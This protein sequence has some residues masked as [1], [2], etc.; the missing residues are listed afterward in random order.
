MP[1]TGYICDKYGKR[2]TIS[3]TGGFCLLFG[4]LIYYNHTKCDQCFTAEIPFIF[5]G[6][7]YSIFVIAIWGSIGF[8]AKPSQIGTAYGMLTCFNNLGS[9]VLPLLASYTHESTNSYKFVEFLFIL[10]SLGAVLCKILL[11]YWD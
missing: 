6:M 4:H 11:Y 8:I 10:I 1:I 2:M 9:T 5:Y 7:S 3:I